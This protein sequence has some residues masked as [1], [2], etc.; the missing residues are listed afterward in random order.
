MTPAEMRPG[1]PYIVERGSGALGLRRGDLVSV[2]ED[3]AL[4]RGSA[5]WIAGWSGYSFSVEVDRGGLLEKIAG[6]RKRAD[7]LEGML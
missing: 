6:L 4:C 2:R 5:C 7:E 3:G 1:L